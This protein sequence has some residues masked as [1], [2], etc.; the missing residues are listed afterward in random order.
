MTTTTW[1]AL[2]IL[3]VCLVLYLMR[4]KARLDRDND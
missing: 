3:A 2:G 1:V 4:R